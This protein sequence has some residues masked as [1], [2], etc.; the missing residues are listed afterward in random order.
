M[1]LVT[2]GTGLVGSHLL[3]KLIL[4]GGGVKA[5]YRSEKKIEAVKRIFSYYSKEFETLFSRIE[6]VKAT[7]NDIPSLENAFN[8]VTQVYHCAAFISLE[9]KYYH[10]LRRVNI[11]GTAN[12]VNLC[13]SHKIDKLCYVSSIATTGMEENDQLITEETH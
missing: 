13:I 10:K 5:I 7:L 1:I 11:E 12:I 2:G 9:T 3:Y 4:K 8:N 6:W